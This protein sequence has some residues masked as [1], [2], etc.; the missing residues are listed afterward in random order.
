[1]HH[2]GSEIHDLPVSRV[3][4]VFMQARHAA[5]TQAIG[6]F[7]GKRF[8]VR[9]GSG[10]GK[11]Q[12]VGNIAAVCHGKHGN[13]PRFFRVQNISCG[14]GKGL[15]VRLG[16]AWQFRPVF[17][18]KFHIISPKKDYFLVL[19]SARFSPYPVKRA[20]PVPQGT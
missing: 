19:T 5:L 11:H 9:G 18:I 3:T 14:F 8:Y 15:G 12:I 6:Q 10:A 17:K 7:P 2:H 20:C 4:P 16:K 1:M 13:I